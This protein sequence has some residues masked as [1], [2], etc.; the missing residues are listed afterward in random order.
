M[1]S[2]II[3]A[4][5]CV[6]L[7]I[8]AQPYPEKT[9]RIVVTAPPGGSDDFMGRLLAQRVSDSLGKRV[10]VDNRVGGG[11]LIGREYVARSA[12]DGYTLLMA[13]SAMAALPALHPGVKLDVVNDFAPVSLFA[14]YP[15]MMVAHPSLPVKTVKDLV[16]L[17][18]AQPGRLNFGSSG[19]G[20][21]PHLA[22]ELFKSMA[23][24][25]MVH[26]PYQG[27]GP[28]YVALMAGEVELAF[29]VIAAAVPHVR[30]GKV[31]ALAVSGAKR[32]PAAPQI[33]TVAESGVPGY[34]FPSWMGVYGPAGMPRNVVSLLNGEV[35]KVVALP[36]VQ[37]RM[38]DSGLEPQASTPER[39]E[40]MLKANIA[41]VSRIVH[42][43][44]IRID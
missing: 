27:S 21:G 35:Q 29:G 44:K 19:P 41:K 24:I 6:P 38:L 5:M 8:A 16:A 13:G 37:K 3:A 11:A 12:P 36:D 31:R 9:V 28:G 2:L 17:A 26:I 39:L 23:K 10:L 20:Q 25:D 33:P 22:M 14:T 34:E 15:L 40:E 43:A 42:D 32:T 30:T 18:R 1:K 4:L 7:A